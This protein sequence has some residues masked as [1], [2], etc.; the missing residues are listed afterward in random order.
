MLMFII[1]IARLP[2]RSPFGSL[3]VSHGVRLM[4]SPVR[5]EMQAFLPYPVDRAMLIACVEMVRFE[6]MTPCLQGRCSPN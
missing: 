4:R 5:H 3:H 6:L 2:F 1:R